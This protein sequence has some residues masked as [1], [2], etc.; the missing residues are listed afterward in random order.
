MAVWKYSSLAV[1]YGDRN[2]LEM[3]LVDIKP[4][5]WFIVKN[6]DDIE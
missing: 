3:F 1:S 6:E 4:T 2:V 5:E